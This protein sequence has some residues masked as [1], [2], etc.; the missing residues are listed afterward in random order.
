MPDRYDYEPPK[1]WQQLVRKMSPESS[2]DQI[3][4]FYK[5]LKDLLDRVDVENKRKDELNRRYY[6]AKGYDWL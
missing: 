6:K 5:E 3:R 1:E 4:I 2:D